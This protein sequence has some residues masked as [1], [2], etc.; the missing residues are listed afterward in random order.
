MHLSY[1]GVETVSEEMFLFQDIDELIESG[2]ERRRKPIKFKQERIFPAHKKSRTH[3]RKK[4][5]H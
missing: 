1:S 3:R 2:L 4:G 5:P